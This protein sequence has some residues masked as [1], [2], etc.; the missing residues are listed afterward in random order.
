MRSNKLLKIL[1]GGVFAVFVVCI[2]WIGVGYFGI[3]SE[4]S[5]SSSSSSSSK[6]ATDE[7]KY[8][9]GE[10]SSSAN[11]EVIV[12]NSE[13][14]EV[15]NASDSGAT[16]SLHESTTEYQG[17]KLAHNAGVGTSGKVFNTQKEALEYGNSELERLVKEDKKARQFSISK[18]SD[19]DGNLIGWT[20]D[21]FES[22][23]GTTTN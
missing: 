13:T 15:S 4:K 22:G 16:S 19:E 11:N 17:K 14:G 3:K 2:V 7:Q 18:V 1:W 5:S 6:Q 23:E 12:G 20:V 21:I 8:R 9:S 10:S